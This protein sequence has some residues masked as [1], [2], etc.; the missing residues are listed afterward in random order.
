LAE[1]SYPHCWRCKKPVIFRATEQWFISMDKDGLRR[2]A[3]DWIDR[4]EWIP[5]WGR[6]RIHNM[7]ANRPD[8]CI[9]RQRSW[10]VPITVFTCKD[11]GALLATPETFAHVAELFSAQG[12]DCWF[13]LPPEELLP[14]GSRCSQCGGCHFAKEMDI[15]DV[16]FDSGVSHAAVLEA[17]PTLRAPADL[18]LEGS[19]Q[20]RGWFHSSLLAAVGTRDVAP[21][22]SVLTHG[23]VVDGQGY[24]M[25]K[26]VGNVIAPEEII[27]QY[28]AEVLRLWV[29]AEDYRDDIRISPDI[30]K[31][32]SEAYRRIRNTCRFLLGNLSGFD[33]TRHTV[34]YDQL[35]ELDRL[36]L[37]QLQDLMGETRRAYERFEFHRV[38]HA[39][40]NYCVVDLSS[41]YL[42]IL[43]DRLYTA[44]A[45]SAERC[46]AQT[47]LYEVLVT[48]LKIMA[49]ILSFTADEAWWQLRATHP[50][51]PA[52]VHLEALPDINPAYQDEALKERWNTI[53]ALRS[54]VSRALET[55]RQAKVIGHSLD[56][57]VTLGLPEG[58]E[59]A[60]VGQEE[61][62]GTVCIVSQMTVAADGEALD[63]AVEGIAIPGLKILVG[64]AEG[65]KCERCWVWSNTVGRKAEHPTVCKRCRQALTAMGH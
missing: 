30:L 37:H 4:V 13:A 40:H 44:P 22:K 14:S 19:D 54:D 52:S 25:S 18:Y 26:S 53:L 17:W 42:D 64:V 65:A 51:L 29:S 41:F 63:G 6:D 2:K 7:I 39:L 1:H 34:P 61:L 43:K 28:G 9:S 46:S 12:A 58:L 11:C 47:V 15:L 56:A 50:D 33:P 36:A 45:Q 16:W 32:L 59:E 27:R 20:H 10:G 62:L 21:Y 3:L 35:Q 8:W 24:K 5:G 48:V 31:R 57:R 55:A 23:F 38:Y 60:F 49:P